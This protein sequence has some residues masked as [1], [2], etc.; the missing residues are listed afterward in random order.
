MP[1]DYGAQE[2][3]NAKH[4]ADPQVG[5]DWHDHGVPQCVVVWRDGDFLKVCE[6]LIP[7]EYGYTWDFRKLTR[8]SVDEFGRRLRYKSPGLQHK[9]WC[10][11]RPKAI[12]R[13]AEMVQ[14]YG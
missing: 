1:F 3:L 2:R 9:T 14:K 6:T 11:V 8:M 4:L 7:Y 13:V 5:D 12:P 10:S